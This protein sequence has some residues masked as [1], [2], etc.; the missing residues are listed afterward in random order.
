[1]ATA[2]SRWDQGAMVERM[3]S[4]RGRRYPPEFWVFF[5]A[6]VGP[7]IGDAPAIA[8]LGCG[9]GLLLQDLALRLPEAA[10]LGVDVSDAMLSNARG[11]DYANRAP[12]FMQHDLNDAPYPVED[13]SLDLCITASVTCFLDD[14][15]VLFA[16]VRR[17]LRPGG[18]YLL[19]DWRRQA[20]PDYIENRRG[21]GDDWTSLMNVQPYHNRFTVDEWRWLLAEGGF[22]VVG[23]AHPRVSHVAF[24]GVPR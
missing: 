8:D 22:E 24:A 18:V 17:M 19:Y 1:M 4:S 6:C 15:L 7:R 14:P 16:E 2:D 9:P 20:L 10:L 11:L 23:E 12:S 3:S 5:E 13:A 21:S